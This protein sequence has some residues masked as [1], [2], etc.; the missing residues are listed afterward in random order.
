MATY[1]CSKCEMQVSDRNQVY[2]D[3][4]RKIQLAVANRQSKCK[5]NFKFNYATPPAHG[6]TIYY[7]CSKCNMEKKEHWK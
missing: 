1:K 7:K 3:I 2:R 4:Q 6:N 5:H